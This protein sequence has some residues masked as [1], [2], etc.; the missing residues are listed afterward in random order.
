MV[1][2]ATLSF[3]LTSLSQY[4]RFEK[5]FNPQ[6]EQSASKVGSKYNRFEKWFNPQRICSQ[7]GN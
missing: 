2:P 4:N 3:A 6:Q 5:W 7:G 1:Q